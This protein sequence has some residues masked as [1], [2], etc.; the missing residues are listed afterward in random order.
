LGL[1]TWS[2]QKIFISFGCGCEEAPSPNG[3]STA[4]EIQTVDAG[5]QSTR[6]AEV[7]S[8]SLAFEKNKFAF[9]SV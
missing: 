5:G 9:V 8:L 3:G 6:P 7:W 1:I 2:S 4:K